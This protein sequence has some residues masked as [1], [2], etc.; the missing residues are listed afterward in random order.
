MVM[1]LLATVPTLLLGVAI[2]GLAI[3]LA[4]AGLIV[5]RRF[6]PLPVLQA[7]NDVAGFIYAV[8][9]VIYAVLAPFVLVIVWEEFRDARTGVAQE[10]EMLIALGETAQQLPPSIGGP[11][12]D[13]AQRYAR[14]VIADEWPRL[15]HGDSSPEVDR[16][17]AD[18]GT[19][20]HA[21]D[22]TDPRQAVVYDQLLQQFN[23]VRMQRQALVSDSRLAVPPVLW[24]V[25]VLGATL[26]VSY[27]YLYGVV[28]LQAQLAM[29][30]ALTAIIA[31]VLF[32]ILV[33]D[34]PFTG[35]VRV[36]PD[37]LTRALNVLA[38]FH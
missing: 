8:L 16:A 9:G 18:L 22:P 25:L 32:V 30:L 2:V 20:I 28:R 36:E 23:D 5:V 4:I 15:A 6:V 12:V 17:L 10:A 11:I 37:E 24:L 38:S 13:R 26:V 34:Y 35:D 29:T 33:L 27:T 1:R 21:V 31:L 14:A 3:A 7:H 19:A